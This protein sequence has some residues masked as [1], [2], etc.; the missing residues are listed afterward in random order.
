M[1]VSE[2]SR[3]VQVFGSSLAMTLPALFVKANEIE[4][5]CILDV[6]Y[7]LDGILALFNCEDPEKLRGCLVDILHRLEEKVRLDFVDSSV[8]EK[9]MNR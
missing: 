3:K 4:K 6:V 2:S 1:I 7:G 5:G 9:K 8:S